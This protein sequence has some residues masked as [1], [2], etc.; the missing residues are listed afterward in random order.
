MWTGRAGRLRLGWRSH[1]GLASGGLREVRLL[2]GQLRTPKVSVWQNES[3]T[4]FYE[5]TLQ[6]TLC[7]SPCTLLVQVVRS[8]PK[9]IDTA[10]QWEECNI[11]CIHACLNLSIHHWKIPNKRWE[12]RLE[13]VK[14][15]IG[16]T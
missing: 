10:F 9:F 16:R 3:F 13:T 7:L 8:K 4:D 12:E 11:I 1:L 14:M 15:L 5:L 2:M 6:I